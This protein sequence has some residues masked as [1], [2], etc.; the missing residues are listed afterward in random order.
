VCPNPEID[1]N[2][3]AYKETNETTKHCEVS[4]DERY[5]HYIGTRCPRLDRLGEENLDC[6][7]PLANP[8]R[9]Q[10]EIFDSRNW[11]ILIKQ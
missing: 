11:R 1:K 9:K 6:I 2:T 7:H 4:R 10:T 5:V 3:I 8:Y